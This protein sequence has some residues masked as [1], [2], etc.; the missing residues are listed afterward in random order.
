MAVKFRKTSARQSA[1]VNF[2]LRSAARQDAP[3][4]AG[5]SV[6]T[7]TIDGRMREYISRDGSELAC[8]GDRRLRQQ[9]KS[10]FKG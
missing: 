7:A 8:S 10:K 6:A 9:T 3:C 2:K 4:L 5:A 1:G